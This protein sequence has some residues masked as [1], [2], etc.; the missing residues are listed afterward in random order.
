MKHQFL[1]IV[2]F[3]SLI[4]FGQSINDYRT[5]ASGNWTNTG[6]WEVYNGTAWVAATNYPGQTGNTTNDVTIGNGVSVTINSAIPD[7]I[8]SVTIGDS[9]GGIDTLLIGGTSSLNTNQFTIAY[10]GLLNWTINKTFA[11]PAGTNFVVESPNP[12]PSLVLGVDHG[13][14]ENNSACSASKILQIGTVKYATC[15]G[16][17]GKGVISFE[18]V[19]ESGGNLSVTPSVTT[20]PLCANQIIQLNANPGGTEITDTPLT[21]SWSAT[22]PSGYTFSSNIE[23][24][25]DTPTTP[26]VYTY[27]VT[28]TNNSSLS[29]TGTITITVDN[30][31]K[32]IITNR[33]ITFRVNN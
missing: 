19:N 28:L 31:N 10:D 26:G 6:I 27:E 12:N 15:N 21:Y 8:N 30:C 1:F 7:P 2:F 3:L 18:V 4:S 20:S 32:T 23:N 24:P 5:T 11:L 16:N 13:I 33:R 14:F 25:T 29:T 17:G 9:T 22:A